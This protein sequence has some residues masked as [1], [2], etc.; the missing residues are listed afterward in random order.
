ML[1]PLVPKFR[2][3]LPVRLRDVAEKQVPQRLKPIVGESAP[4]WPNSD[5]VEYKSA[6]PQMIMI[7]SFSC[8]VTEHV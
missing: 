3:P 4:F 2:S 7:A 1:E 5:H 6:S 8:E